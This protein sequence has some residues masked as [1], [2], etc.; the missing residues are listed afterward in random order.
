MCGICAWQQLLANVTLGARQ[1]LTYYECPAPSCRKKNWWYNAIDTEYQNLIVTFCQNMLH[2][3]WHVPFVKTKIII[4]YCWWTTTELC[5]INIIWDPCKKQTRV[6]KFVIVW[7]LCRTTIID[8]C[9]GYRY[10]QLSQCGCPAPACS[11][12]CRK[13]TWLYHVFN[14]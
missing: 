7:Y 10:Q 3:Q 5:A 1:Q 13:R 8:K 6:V 2:N 9:H 11:P 12:S 4:L 14:N